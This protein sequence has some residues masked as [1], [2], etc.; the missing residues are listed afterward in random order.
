MIEFSLSYATVYM[1]QS[2]NNALFE[3]ISMKI[4]YYVLG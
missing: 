3:Y 4:D 2:Q 1:Y